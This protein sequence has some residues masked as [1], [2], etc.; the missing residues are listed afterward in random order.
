M[1]HFFVSTGI[2]RLQGPSH[3]VRRD[4]KVFDPLSRKEIEGR[5]K[6]TYVEQTIVVSQ[7]SDDLHL[8]IGT[9]PG[10]SKALICSVRKYSV[11]GLY[12]QTMS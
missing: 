9:I 6:E 2:A 4:T 7:A 3:T 10:K 5:G 11:A 12:V 1:L 8:R